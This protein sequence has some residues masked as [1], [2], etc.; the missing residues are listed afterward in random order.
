MP[1][2]VEIITKFSDGPLFDGD[3]LTVI[4]HMAF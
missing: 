2:K 3:I 4:G 1:Q